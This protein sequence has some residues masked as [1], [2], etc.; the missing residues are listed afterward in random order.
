MNGLIEEQMRSR[1]F[2]P[3]RTFSEPHVCC[4]EFIEECRIK[5]INF[6]LVAPAESAAGRKSETGAL[7]LTVPLA[8]DHDYSAVSLAPPATDSEQNKGV[9]KSRLTPGR[10]C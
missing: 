5:N 10:R 7:L 4:P 3:S 2:D 1:R 6:M 9:R 8:L